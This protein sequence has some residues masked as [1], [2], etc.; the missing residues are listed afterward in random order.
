MPRWSSRLAK[1]ER[2]QSI[3]QLLDTLQNCIKHIINVFGLW[4]LVTV[5]FALMAMNLFGQIPY[6]SG[7]AYVYGVYGEF[8]N[9]ASFTQSLSTLFKVATLDNWTWLMRD[10]MQGQRAAGEYP[11]AWVFFILYLIITAFLF[12]NI[13]TAIVMDQYDFTARV[14]SKP[15]PNGLERQV[16]TFNQASAISEEW[17][18]LD[19]LNTGFIDEFKVRKL[20]TKIG[21]P[22]GFKEGLVKAMQLRHLRRMELRMTGMSMQVNYVDFFIS[23]AVL[24]YRLQRKPVGDLDLKQIKGKLALEIQIAFP[25]ISDKRLEDTGGLLSAVQAINYLQGQYRGLILRRM[26]AAGDKEGIMNYDENRLKQLER[27]AEARAREDDEAKKAL[28]KNTGGKDK[29]GKDKKKKKKK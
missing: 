24:R 1:Y 7:E 8:S 15:R 14:T 5:T 6:G 16:M 12:L 10:I 17:S 20:L 9:F 28:M 19:P 23:C 21:P 26:M 3:T 29:K 18:F 4:L 11:I 22:V 13:F 27:Q 2:V 25:S